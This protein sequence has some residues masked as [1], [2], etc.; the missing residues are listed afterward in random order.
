MT[1]PRAET[2]ARRLLADIGAAPLRPLACSDEHPALGWARSGLMALTGAAD[3]APQLCPAP[4]TSC[5]DG[6]LA[7][8]ASL[9]P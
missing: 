7:A 1:L 8:L 9:A 5:A 6:A 2:Y 3:D 4:L